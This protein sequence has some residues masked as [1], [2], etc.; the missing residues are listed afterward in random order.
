V[1]SATLS[2]EETDFSPPTSVAQVTGHGPMF[3]SFQT[4]PNPAVVAPAIRYNLTA[5]ARVALRIYN[6]LGQEVRTLV[7][8]TQSKGPKSVLWDRKDNRGRLVG[9]GTYFCRLQA[10]QRERTRQ[11]VLL[12]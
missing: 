10:G 11:L 4:C 2:Y 7:N 9:A 1:D 3:R 6:V 12:R 5:S 8:G